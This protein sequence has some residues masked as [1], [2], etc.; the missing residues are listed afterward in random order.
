[1]KKEFTSN[2]ESLRKFF[3][4]DGIK[5]IKPLSLLPWRVVEAQHILSSRDLVDTIEEHDLLE[6]LLE[7]SNPKSML[8]KNYLIFTP[9]RYPPLKYG[10]RFGQ[11]F[12]PSIWYGSIEIET[13]F[14]EVAYYQQQFL[15]DTKANLDYIELVMTAFNAKIETKYGLDLTSKPFS[16][17]HEYISAKNNY[18]T[19]QLLGTLMREAGVEAFV[20]FSARSANLAKNIGA[21]TSDVFKPVKNL[22]VFNQQ[23]WKCISSKHSVEF[24][25]IGSEGKQRYF[26]VSP[27]S[28]SQY[29]V[30]L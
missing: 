29:S 23:T 10:S 5:H 13:A 4:C 17:Y 3:T 7:E 22:Y 11:T 16:D 8:L 30:V 27:N 28:V 20:Y 6:E 18:A 19:S 15:H 25:R 12:E 9:F 2:F 24:T 14:S 1:M 21:Y 26:Y